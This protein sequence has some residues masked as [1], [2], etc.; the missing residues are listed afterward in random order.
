MSNA[1][2]I[3]QFTINGQTQLALTDHN[4]LHFSVWVEGAAETMR[5]VL[6]QDASVCWDSGTL[7]WQPYYHASSLSLLPKKRYD[8][9][10]TVMGSDGR[11]E[12]RAML[13]TGFMGQPWQA[14]WIEPQQE[15]AVHER[16]ILFFEQ[17]VPMPDHFGGHE[18]LRPVQEL[19]RVFTLE[20]LPRAATLYASAHGVYALW[21][22]G[23]RVDERRLA[24]ETTPYESLLYYQIYDLTPFLQKGENTL[25]VL[26]AD[27]W[28]IGRI[29]LTGHS[30]QYGDRLGFL[31]RMEFDYD[32]ETDCIVTDDEFES[33]PSHICYADLF[34]GEKWDMTT[35][36]LPWTPC[37]ETGEADATLAVQP[38]APIGAWETINPVS[39][40]TTPNGELVAD[41]GQCLAGVAEIRLD[42]PVGTVVTLDHSETLDTEGNF[43]R[44]ILGRNK[45]QQDKVVC[46]AGETVFCPEFTYH[47]FRYVRIQGAAREQV[48]SIRA[49]LI[50]T[51]LDRLGDFSCSDEL[52]TK[53]QSNICRSTRSNMV[54][55]PTDCPQREKMGWTGDIQ[56]FA[57][58]G[59]FNYDLSGFLGAWLG[60]MRLS[61]TEDGGIP[62]IIP[63]YPAQTA[64]QLSTNGGNTSS[65]WSDACVLVPLDLYRMY[66]DEQVL[67]DNLPM[68]ARWMAYIASASRDYLWQEGYHFGDWLIPSYQ[69]DIEGGTK[70]TAPVIAAC[71]YAI[72]TAAFIEVLEALDSP[73]EKIESYRTLLDNIRNAIRCAFVREGGTV[74]G[75]LQGLYVM[76]LHC[77]AVSGALAEKVAARLAEKIE[78]NGGAL[79][80]G[81]VSTP[82]LLNVLMQ[83]GYKDLAW[84]L[85]LRTESPGWL[86]QVVCGATTIWENW[87]AIRP[88]GT[89][90]TSS[91]NHY[92]LGSVGSWIYRHIGGLHPL[93]AGWRSIEFAPDI[94]CGLT[95]AQCSHLTPYGLAA[96]RWTRTESGTE[97]KVQ[98]PC[99]VT[100]HLRL[101]EE[102][103]PLSAG[104]H[105][106][107][108]QNGGTHEVL[109]RH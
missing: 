37:I 91:Y 72:T 49:K 21:L 6:L 57:P 95:W 4:D 54:S 83:Y 105:T 94:H 106:I 55:V 89:I 59:S 45:D 81:F 92:A 66:G 19:R 24:P 60:Q 31:G 40:A 82:H 46:G 90:T 109:S 85:L 51:P 16:D 38:I 102:V 73:A 35:P 99:G 32:G 22:N 97:I 56:V 3:T 96:C 65:A 53:L 107:T 5:I 7:P 88:D 29:G 68:M 76:V 25:R 80:T 74:E 79:D 34:M 44:N 86:Y 28:W 11:A 50:G 64:M 93:S 2:S 9:T 42:C 87:N 30:C 47:G 108:A 58:T 77:G 27:G 15:S 84:R 48:L 14:Q 63:T 8:V 100:A 10:V 33:R 18:R 75:D 26:L 13:C 36:D 1:L 70:V 98:V 103:Y 69:D 20:Q 78:A 62:I 43:F 61:Q 101:G 52:L 41:F 23:K 67:R 12:A 71:Q 17:F 39:L 104:Q